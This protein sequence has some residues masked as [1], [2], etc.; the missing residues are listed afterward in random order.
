[1]PESKRH[2]IA[3]MG[4]DLSTGGAER[5]MANIS[6][7]LNSL[8]YEVHLVVFNPRID[9]PFQGKLH[10]IGEQRKENESILTRYTYKLRRFLRLK[11]FFK[12]EKPDV[13]IDFR[14]RENALQELL[15]YK[16]IYKG[17]RIQT[18]RSGAYYF[19]LFRNKWLS[20]YIFKNFDRIICISDKQQ[21]RIKQDLGFKNLTVIPNPTNPERI[22]QLQDEP[23]EIDF[24]YIVAVGRL[25]PEKQFDLLVEAYSKTTLVQSGVKLVIL[26]TGEEE[27]KIR[28]TIDKVNLAESVILEGYQSNSFKYMKNALFLVL[29]SKYEGLPMVLLECLSCG[30]PVVAFD[31]FSGPSEIVNHRENGLLTEDQNFEQL[32]KDIDLLFKDKELYQTCKANALSSVAKFRPEHIAHKWEVLLAELLSQTNK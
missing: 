9:C 15:I 3:L 2:K 19:Y 31:C 7:V 30:T 1:M 14:F 12:K 18:V 11:S 4:Y 23:F 21:D 25:T 16:L 32:A 27:Q 5:S 22:K 28:Q 26:G 29:S 20:K 10:I 17:I 24:P 8:N 6:F 13:V